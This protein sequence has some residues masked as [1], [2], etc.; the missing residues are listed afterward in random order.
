MKV[1]NAEIKQYTDLETV[2]LLAVICEY[3]F[4][5]LRL[6]AVQMRFLS[7]YPVLLMNLKLGRIDLTSP[8]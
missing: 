4:F 5:R 7:S 3:F 1:L 2:H 6:T 8:T